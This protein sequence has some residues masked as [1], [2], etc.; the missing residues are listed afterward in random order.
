MAAR[1]EWALLQHHWLPCSSLASPNTRSETSLYP[2]RNFSVNKSKE[3][4]THTGPSTRAGEASCKG[5][6]LQLCAL[7]ICSWPSAGDRQGGQVRPFLCQGHSAV[8]T[9]GLGLLPSRQ[10]PAGLL[11]PHRVP[12]FPRH[13]RT[14]TAPGWGAVASTHACSQPDAS[15]QWPGQGRGPQRAPGPLK[16]DLR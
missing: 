10:L 16:G 15:V 14:P 7:P 3:S 5:S 11:A 13:H 1:R 2:Q 4:V 6:S 12:S 9:V 8:S